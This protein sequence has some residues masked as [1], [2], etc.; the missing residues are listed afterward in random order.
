[1][2]NRRELLKNSAFLSAIAALGILAMS[3]GWWILSKV[4]YYDPPKWDDPKYSIAAMKQEKKLK[5]GTD[6]PYADAELERMGRELY[7]SDLQKWIVINDLAGNPNPVEIKLFGERLDQ[8]E[9]YGRELGDKLEPVQGMEDLFNGVSEPSAEMLM[10]IRGS[11]AAKAGLTPEQIATAL[12]SAR[13]DALEDSAIVPWT[14]RGGVIA[15]NVVLSK[16]NAYI[17]DSEIA[18]HNDGSV[19]LD[20]ENVSAINASTTSSDRKSTRLN[21]SHRT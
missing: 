14:G 12:D 7:A 5:P 4:F 1:M 17:T 20:A 16:A 3:V 11:E 15:T 18:T 21:S 19:A 6:Q 9:A 10:R 13:I 8:L 2:L